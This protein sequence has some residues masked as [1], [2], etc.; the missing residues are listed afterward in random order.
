MYMYRGSTLLLK[1]VLCG[2][3]LIVLAFC[4]LVLPRLISAELQGDFD[5]APILIGM[6]VPAVPFFI[7]LYQAFKLLTHIDRN[8]AF[9]ELSV[10][11][12]RN[13]TYCALTISG[14]YA[15]GMP[16]IFYVADR[17]DAPGLVALGFV[18][19]GASFVV[20]TFAAV[21]RSLLQNALEIQSENDLTV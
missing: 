9:S 7:G 14:L 21:L 15:L 11:A 20:A 16:Y 3:G 10:K 2:I 1:S 19:I 12:L 17:D 6:Y 8:Q 13:I 4:T 5:Y 18:I